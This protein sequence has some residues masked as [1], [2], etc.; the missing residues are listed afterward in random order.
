LKKKVSEGVDDSDTD[1]TTNNG[2]NNTTNNNNNNNNNTI[3]QTV[4]RYKISPKSLLLTTE[5]EYLITSKIP[6]SHNST[7]SD[8][9]NTWIKNDADVMSSYASNHSHDINNTTK[10][11][12]CDQK[13]YAIVSKLDAIRDNLYASE[14]VCDYSNTDSRPT[15]EPVGDGRRSRDAS[16]K[17]VNGVV[18]GSRTVGEREQEWERELDDEYDYDITA[19]PPSTAGSIRDKSRG[20]KSR[21]GDTLAQRESLLNKPVLPGRDGEKENEIRSLTS[22]SIAKVKNVYDQVDPR[23]K[24]GKKKKKVSG[25]ADNGNVDMKAFEKFVNDVNDVN[26]DASKASKNNSELNDAY[27]GD[28]KNDYGD[29]DDVSK[30]IEAQLKKKYVERDAFYNT[31]RARNRNEQSFVDD[32]EDYAKHAEN[33]AQEIQDSIRV[34]SMSKTERDF[35]SRRG[36]DAGPSIPSIPEPITNSS[37]PSASEMRNQY[38]DNNKRADAN[39]EVVNAM[40][41]RINDMELEIKGLKSKARGAEEAALDFSNKAKEASRKLTAST[42]KFTSAMQEKDDEHSRN[43]L[44]LGSELN[45]SKAEAANLRSQMSM[46]N[47][48]QSMNNANPSNSS[49]QQELLKKVE[50]LH[51]E[52]SD[53][54]KRFN[55]EKRALMSAQAKNNQDNNSIHRNEMNEIRNVNSQLEDKIGDMNESMR[56]IEKDKGLLNQKL[57]DS[58]KKRTLALMDAD[59]LRSDVKTLQQSLQA[60]QSLDMAQGEMYKDGESTIAALQATSDARIR[61]LNN[62]VEYLKAQLASEA[63]LKDQYAVTITEL[64]K[65]REDSQSTA[66]NKLKELESLKERELVQLQEQMRESMDGPLNEVSHL[67]GKVA[68]LQAQLGDAMQDIAQARKKEEAARGETGKERSKISSIQHELNMANNELENAKEEINILKENTSNAAANEAMLRRLDNERQYLKNQLTSEVTCK[69]ELQETLERTTRQ[70]GEMKAAWKSESDGLTMKI[71]QEGN[72]RDAIETELHAKVQGYE[73]DIK[74][75]SAQL[76]DLKEAFTKTRDQLRLDQAAVENMRATTARLAEELKAAQD[77]LVSAKKAEQESAI[78]HSQNMK[79]VTSTVAQAEDARRRESER[80]QAETRNALQQTSEVQRQMMVLKEQMGLAGNAALK[81]R[82]AQTVGAAMMKWMKQQLHIGFTTWAKA[83][84]MYRAVESAQG[85]IRQAVKV[86][87]EK[88]K[89]EREMACRMVMAKMANEKEDTIRRMEEAAAEDRKKL[90]KAAQDDINRAVD[91]ERKRSSN[92]LKENQLKMEEQFRTTI[93]KHKLAVKDMAEAH[94]AHQASIKA[95][96]QKDIERAVFDA[97]HQFLERQTGILKENDERWKHMIGENEKR[98]HADFADA[99]KKRNAEFDALLDDHI[100]R[101]EGEKLAL[102]AKYKEDTDKAVKLEEGRMQIE[103]TKAVAQE[104]FKNAQH[105]N[106]E[107]DRMRFELA[108]EREE[109]D[110]RLDAAKAKWNEELDKMKET[111]ETDM[112][113]NYADRVRELGDAEKD[114]RQKAVRLEAGKWQKALRETEDRIEAERLASFKK[115]AAERDVTAQ[116]ELAELK[117]AANLALEKVKESAKESLKQA[118]SES[119]AQLKLA[120]EHA[121]R[122]MAAAIEKGLREANEDKM[123]A[124][125][126]AINVFSKNA[127]KKKE[128]AVN[129]ATAREKMATKRVEAELESVTASWRRDQTELVDLKQQLDHWK[130]N[131]QSDLRN[132]ILAA[133]EAAAKAKEQYDLQLSQALQRL[134]EQLDEIKVKELEEATNKHMEEKD[135]AVR[136]AQKAAEKEM[137]NALGALEAES[138][139]LIS[140]LE[141]AMAG[142]RR[143][144]QETEQELAETKSMLEE[145]EDS[146]YDLQTAAKQKQKETSFMTLRLT[147]GAIKQRITYLKMLDD[148]EKEKQNEVVFMTKEAARADEK[149][150]REISVLDGILDACKQQRELMHETLVNHKRETLV[151]HKVQSGVISR[152]LESIALERDSVEGQREALSKQL[153]TME[154]SLKDLEEQ[155]NI[156]AKTSTI[157]GGRVNVSHARKKRRLDEEFEALLE[158]MEQ[159]RE[160][161]QSVD[162]KLKELMMQKEESEDKMKQLERTLVEVLVEQ[163]KKLLSILAQKPEDV[164]RQ[165][166]EDGDE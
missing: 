116:K 5:S 141:Q 46:L 121:S 119:A 70:L 123:K 93:E 62:K 96:I 21:G 61:T 88:M 40:R 68:A 94:E 152:E 32:I 92:L 143:S 33:E 13:F 95:G 127:E 161:L 47:S 97:E 34:A 14:S 84:M 72:R 6:L 154:G 85:Q 57:A 147:T 28:K 29:N 146:I 76:I 18:N 25:V 112:E 99:N 65:E 109:S 133:E 77:E 30:R 139:K 163:Q 16:K 82:A 159:K 115:G 2:S 1:T 90:V 42:K 101:F 20:D 64:R 128:D 36:I 17:R 129:A 74:T 136:E 45:S 60:T 89:E 98:L 54:Q 12:Y 110:G 80:L 81:T 51:K 140:S 145:N 148:K 3:L 19:G 39:S 100:A 138:E 63:S 75:Q 135:N 142:L 132:H 73:A 66:K 124:V 43:L 151:E 23:S 111:W 87:E 27:N 58:E 105:L 104:S 4:Q 131:S 55:E 7:S 114:K 162:D 153:S 69:N 157:Q 22:K 134:R 117:Q 137:E 107:M 150:K 126:E 86:T 166:R 59:K 102:Q 71:R 122:E 26:D 10:S 158:N 164:A 106:K 165:L 11:V 113:A 38:N 15:S 103:L 155:I 83:A 53:N 31:K 125:E 50:S 48:A 9:I 108:R 144:K 35:L 8:Y 160:E 52:M 37:Y 49:Y 41:D 56:A 67:Q 78:R 118:L 120:R 130:V 149:R 79:T 24:K 91:N 44:E 156:H